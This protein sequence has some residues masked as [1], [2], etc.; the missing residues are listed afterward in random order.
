MALFLTFVALSWAGP[1]IAVTTRGFWTC[2]LLTMLKKANTFELMPYAPLEELMVGISRESAEG[3]AE[4]TE[5]AWR[6]WALMEQRKR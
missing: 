2:D 5:R 6:R 4:S 3:F 1:Q